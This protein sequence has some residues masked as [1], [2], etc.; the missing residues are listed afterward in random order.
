MTANGRE[1]TRMERI[2]VL[3]W[4]S[5]ARSAKA[6]RRPRGLTLLVQN[7]S[8]SLAFIRG[9]IFGF[10]GSDCRAKRLKTVPLCYRY[11]S[12]SNPCG[13]PYVIC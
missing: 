10:L 4:L 11:H 2:E 8:R 13:G 1:G 6:N 9:F 3:S 12:R 5:G 7:Y